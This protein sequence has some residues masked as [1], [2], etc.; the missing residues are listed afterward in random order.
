MAVSIMIVDDNQ[1]IIDL[2]LPH[3]K[4][5]GYSVTVAHDGIEALSLFEASKHHLI[6]LDIMMPKMDG[7]TA[8]KRIREISNVPI[9]MITAKSEDEDVIM[10]IDVGADDYIVKPFSPSRVM[11][12]VK[13]LLR[14]LE[15]NQTE[16]KIIHIDNLTVDMNE[17]TCK[18]DHT[19]ISLTKKEIELLYLMAKNIGKTYS[20][21]IL[22]SILWGN[23]YFGDI[24]TVDTHI[25][26]MRAK[27]NMANDTSTWEIKTIWGVGYKFERKTDI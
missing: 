3:F 25:K 16:D 5:E 26:R 12:K 11:A 1:D 2:L 8:C 27:L 7:M 23:D 17:Y 15:I 14:R 24:R 20:R 21:E 9:I 10:G 22:L 6:L 18:I 19:S 13:A 4:K